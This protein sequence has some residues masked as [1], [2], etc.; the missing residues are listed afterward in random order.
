MNAATLQSLLTEQEGNEVLEAALCITGK[1][2]G[3]EAAFSDRALTAA[4]KFYP[5][6]VGLKELLSIAAQGS[7]GYNRF[8]ADLHDQFRA[9]FSAS[10]PPAEIR[11]AGFSTMS[12]T[13]ILSNVANKFFLSGFDAIESSWRSISSVS[14]APD[15]KDLSS[16]RLTGDFEYE[17]VGPDGEIKHGTLGEQEYGNRVETYAKM[18]TITRRMWIDDDLGALTT[19]PKHLG[20]GAATAFNKVFWR[21]FMDNA[22]FFTTGRGNLLEGATAGTDDTRLNIEG[23]TRAEAAFLD[24]TTPD[25]DPL[26]VE[27][28]VLLVPNAL[29][30]LA[31]QLMNSV[32]VRTNVDGDSYGTGN[33]HAGNYTVVRSSYL[34]NTNFTGNSKAAW[35]LIADPEDLAVI[36]AAF[37]DGR[38]RP[39]IE[40]A[41]ADFST[42]GV[43]F[44]GVHEF[45]IR[46]QEYRAGVRMKGEA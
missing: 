11:A 19:L 21:E 36:N 24:Q 7:P 34:G 12:M 45:G 6:G 41:Q 23:L 22:A 3:V 16:Y 37:L 1:L 14:S 32:E 9:A 44:R 4:A 15:F 40:S 10:S 25:G 20:R 8:G 33:P 43:S 5:R 30:A 29:G 27:P 35:Y 39:T 13:G 46:K 26:G 2:P 18:L 17:K 28:K 31:R 42:L 38:D